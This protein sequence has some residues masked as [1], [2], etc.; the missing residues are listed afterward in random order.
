MSNFVVLG[1][2]ELIAVLALDPFK[3]GADERSLPSGTYE[4]MPEEWDRFWSQALADAGISGLTPVRT[5][6]WHVRIGEFSNVTLL[7]NVLEA[8]FR[9]LSQMGFSN[10]QEHLPL[11]GGFALRCGSQNVLIEPT[12]CADL[13]N[14]ADW[15]D[16]VHY[17]RAEW[18]TLWIGHPWLSVQYRE[19]H[20]I[21]GGPHERGDPT[22]RWAVCPDKLGAA[23][24][25]VESELERFAGQVADALPLRHGADARG[26]GRKLAGLRP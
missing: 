23:V 22:A 13:G 11:D 14:L 1:D 19:P 15:R 24:A 17:R 2:I 18:R 10:E 16:A 4:D 5:G 21:I 26:M 3:L 7:G 8:T 6:S 25:A 12:C 9:N 20:L